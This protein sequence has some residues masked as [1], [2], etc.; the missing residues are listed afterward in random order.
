MRGISFSGNCQGPKL[1]EQF[2]VITGKSYVL[3]HDLQN[4]HWLKI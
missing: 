2:V 4:D 3:N 1:F